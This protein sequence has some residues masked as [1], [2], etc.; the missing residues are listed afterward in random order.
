MKQKRQKVLQCDLEDQVSLLEVA[1]PAANPWT[2]F[3]V[4]EGLM[5][6]KLHHSSSYFTPL[7][8]T[9]TAMIREHSYLR[10][11]LDLKVKS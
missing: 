9:R 5:K 1:E 6:D 3:V 11:S 4:E 7:L 8:I 2:M 10:S